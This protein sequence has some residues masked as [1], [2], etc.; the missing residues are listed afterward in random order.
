MPGT[1]VQATAKGMCGHGGQMTAIGS[2]AR[3]LL[4]G[5]PAATVADIHPIVGCAFTVGPKYS[6]CVTGSQFVPAAR[7]FIMGQPA[8]LI[9]SQ[10]LAKSAEQAPQGPALITFTQTRVVGS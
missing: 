3:V 7:V 4:S 9:T 8:V 2:G 6:P 5:L 1:L 10:G